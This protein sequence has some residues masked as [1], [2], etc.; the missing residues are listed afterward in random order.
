[1]IFMSDELRNQSFSKQLRGYSVEEVE[2]Y[3]DRVLEC[4]DNLAGEYTKLE[5][6]FREFAAKAGSLE[7]KGREADKI[8]ADARA[9][10][11]RI[12]AQARGN[13]AESAQK[14]LDA[15]HAQAE[16]MTQDAES[17]VRSQKRTYNELKTQNEQFRA[18]IVKLC[19]DYIRTASATL[20]D[21]ILEAALQEV[22]SPQ[23]TASVSADPAV[24]AQEAQAQ[25]APEPTAKEPAE[26]EA[27][28]EKPAAGQETDPDV[29]FAVAWLKEN[30]K[31]QEEKPE[32]NPFDISFLRSETDGEETLKVHTAP[33]SGG[34]ARSASA[35]DA[36]NIA[37]LAGTLKTESKKGVFVAAPAKETAAANARQS[38]SEM[39]KA[40]GNPG[41][42][43][44]EKRNPLKFIP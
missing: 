36:A 20:P 19:S 11:D 17:L 39:M 40:L 29:E 43:I 2:S 41:G 26:K 7:D 22:R 35:G 27:A 28:D 13:A 32:E 21:A 33:L 25:T 1:M 18:E 37:D 10:A 5:K 30:R 42:G 9:E 38:Y 3:I 44:P 6:G 8:L 34:L 4:Y 16:Q 23:P 12:L 14:I 31:L 15:A 24:K